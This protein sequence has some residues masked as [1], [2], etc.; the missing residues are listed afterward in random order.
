MERNVKMM[1]QHGIMGVVFGMLH[2]DGRIDKER[3]RRLIELARPM[4]VTFHRA[5]DMANDPYRALDDLLELGVDRLLTSGQE[6]NAMRGL[7]LITELQ[8]RAGDDMI[9]MP[10]V[11]VTV[12]NARHIVEA[13]KV[14]EIHVGSNVER[15]IQTGMKYQNP[16][17]SMGDD[18]ELPEF[19]M[20]YTSA[21]L[22][23]EI[24]DAIS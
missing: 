1:H 5:F 24:A 10:A 11:E 2:S 21:E 14:R 22:V 4:Q 9:I 20:P 13:A 23:R 16:R 6:L 19:A 17:V 18:F 8:K 15:Q 7:G 12:E 3:T